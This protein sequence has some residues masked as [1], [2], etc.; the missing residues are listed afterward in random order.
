MSHHIYAVTIRIDLPDSTR[1][2]GAMDVPGG[3]DWRSVWQ[4]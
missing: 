2:P 4:Q 1:E 3:F